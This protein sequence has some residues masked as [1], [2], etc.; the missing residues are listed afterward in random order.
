MSEDPIQNLDSIDIIGNRKDGG[1]DLCIVVSGVLENS[2]HHEN[3]LRQKVQSYV[4][5]I[6]SDQWK[7]EYG[8]KPVNILLTATEQ[9]HQEIIN[10]IGALKEYLADYNVDLYLKYA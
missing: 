4:N 3:L 2:D 7:E 1:I 6:F 9:P 5:A 10:L 8:D